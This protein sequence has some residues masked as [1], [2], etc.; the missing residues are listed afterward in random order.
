[1]GSAAFLEEALPHTVFTERPT[2]GDP[3]GSRW[4][5]MCLPPDSGG[6]LS[7]WGAKTSTQK[8]K[9][10]KVF[11]FQACTLRL[12]HKIAMLKKKKKTKLINMLTFED[13]KADK[14][15]KPISKKDFL[16]TNSPLQP[17]WKEP[18]IMISWHN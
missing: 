7:S 16:M 1:M 14:I 8:H 11:I 5:H 4:E 12:F 10:R 6:A 15:T 18:M 13:K 17:F 9:I 2:K 3:K